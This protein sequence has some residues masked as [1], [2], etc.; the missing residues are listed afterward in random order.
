MSECGRELEY[1]PL[2]SCWE[3][4]AEAVIL[5]AVK[6]Y[7]GALKRLKRCPGNRDLLRKKRECERFFRSRWF[8]VLCSMDPE[9]LLERIRKEEAE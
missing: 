7:R 2:R 8:A 9:M 6:D 5:Q 1:D 3:D 4:L